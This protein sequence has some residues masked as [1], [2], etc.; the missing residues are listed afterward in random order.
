MLLATLVVLA[1]RTLVAASSAA[2]YDYV[3]VGSGPGGGSLASVDT[4]SISCHVDI[5]LT[6]W[7][8][9]NLALSGQSVFLI[10]AGGDASDSFLERIPQL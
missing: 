2:E 8:R 1:A 5:V 6:S 7:C 4:S 10:E 9:A 3:I